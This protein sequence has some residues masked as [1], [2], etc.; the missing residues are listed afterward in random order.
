[1]T[2]TPDKDS[3][4]QHVVPDWY[5]DAKLGIFIH[6]GLFS[7]PAF[8][9]A[10]RDYIESSKKEDHFANNP[11]AEW[12]LNSLRIPESPTQKFHRKSYGKGFSYD[13]FVPIFN[14]KI[15]K[16]NP[17]EMAELF[18]KAGAQYVVLVTKHHDG[19][20]LWPSTYP[21][22]KKENYHANRDI[23][24][25]LSDAV[26]SKGMKM[27]FYYSGVLDWSFNSNSILNEKGILMNQIMPSEYVQYANN[28]WYEL[29]DRYEPI[30]LWNDIGY[31]WGTNIYE[32]FAYFYNKYP[33]GVIN[34]RWIQ[35]TQD[36]IRALQ[37]VPSETIKKAE[38][39]LLK[40]EE[41]ALK[42][43]KNK[44]THIKKA[45]HYDF[46]T[47]EYQTFSVILDQKWET[48][49]GI[50]QS[51][52]YNKLETEDDYLTSEKLIRMFVDIVS[53]NG[54]LLLN[55]GPMADGTIPEI[56][57]ER[58]LDLG[59][60]LAVN[61]EAI[62]GT[63]PWDHAEG[64][65]LDGIDIRY[66]QNQEALFVILLD[67]PNENKLTVK[68]LKIEKSSR[69][70]LISQDE[71]LD[72]KQEGENLTISIPESIEDIPAYAL[73]VSPKLVN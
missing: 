53:K 68:S 30:I 3:V 33:E 20:V 56:Q 50:G 32:I 66:T 63:R 12:Y 55:V 51:F 64:I 22:P 70:L 67:K 1:M 40:W 27:G 2:Y 60:W 42:R 34:D 62:Y 23:V 47:P 19:F 73:K 28:H 69:I 61:G 4:S 24:G 18:R 43:K 38:S 31:P 48:T 58:L 8:A 36:V 29:I 9:V 37:S 39:Y 44:R 71:N 7:V 11:Y 15:Q 45:V 21:N 16:W 59:K 13:D 17:G 65:T 10:G 49:R 26:K 6:W 52:G 5:H 41:R 35:M 14:E 72:W 57:R 25:E 46:I 54:N